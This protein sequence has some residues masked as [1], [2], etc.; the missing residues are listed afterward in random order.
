MTTNLN[1]DSITFPNPDYICQDPTRALAASLEVVRDP[2]IVHCRVHKLT[3]FVLPPVEFLCVLQRLECLVQPDLRDN[4]ND[5]STWVQ[6][7]A[8]RLVPDEGQSFC[9]FTVFPLHQRC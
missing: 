1:Y 7:W 9:Q 3:L 8:Q 5:I 4:R 6:A 2:R